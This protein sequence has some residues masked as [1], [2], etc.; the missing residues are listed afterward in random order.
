MNT[1]LLF[2]VVWFTW[3]IASRLDVLLLRLDFAVQ[4]I[5][6]CEATQA[7]IASIE[8]TADLTTENIRRDHDVTTWSSVIGRDAK[9]YFAGGQTNP[10]SASRFSGIWD[11]HQY[12]LVATATVLARDIG[13]DS[14]NLSTEEIESFSASTTSADCSS[15]G[16]Q[17]LRLWHRLGRGYSAEQREFMIKQALVA[18][19]IKRHG[20]SASLDLV[21]HTSAQPQQ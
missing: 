11:A 15:R 1:C 21:K 9:A 19:Y 12:R 10:S 5:A 20:W 17:V 16:Y 2:V 8:G 4:P 7:H 14:Y 3:T 13:L 18:F 6:L